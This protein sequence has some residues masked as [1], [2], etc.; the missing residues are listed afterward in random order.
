[1]ASLSLSD[2]DELLVV[3]RATEML[4]R[5]AASAE[6]LGLYG[7][8]PERIESHLRDA[9]LYAVHNQAA[10]RWE[11]DRVRYALSRI[12]TPIVLLKGAAYVA[13]ELHA[14][15]GRICTDSDILVSAEKL[16][17][18]EIA[19]NEH[20][21]EIDEHNP[22]DAE[23]YRRWL[24]ELPPL[25]H[26]ERNTILDV[27]HNILPRIDRLHVDSNLLFEQ[28]LPL[29]QIGVSV[30]APPDMVLHSAA[31]LFRTTDFSNTLRDLSDID[32]LI[33]Q[34]AQTDGF[35][36][37]LVARATELR[38]R[39]PCAHGIRLS[40]MLFETPIPPSVYEMVAG[41]KLRGTTT[42]LF[43]AMVRRTLIPRYSDKS[44]N[45]GVLCRAVLSYCPPPRLSVLSTPLFW[46]KRLPRWL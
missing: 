43:D 46:T 16:Q 13:A 10:T 2:W 41:K 20:G 25:R 14:A 4:G 38:L 24:Q 1:M 3:A 39:A 37:G 32:A 29:S 40:R 7:D 44:D 19:L 9:Y 5:L 22:R 21:W 34:F 6:R 15:E 12:D 45:F 27:H 30:L 18:V 31:H 35:W 11:I 42:R 36:E 26:R 28:I 17:E 8:I 23:Y 33:R